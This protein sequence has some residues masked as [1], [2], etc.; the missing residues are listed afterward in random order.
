MQHIHSILAFSVSDLLVEHAGMVL[1]A[2]ILVLTLIFGLGDLLRFSGKRI[3][4][5]SSVCFAESIRRK[6]LWITPVAIIGVMVVAQLQRP[7]DEQDAIRQTTKFCLFATG[8]VV[9][10]VAILLAS[11]SLPKEI[12]NRVIFTIVT[13]PTTRLEIVLGK[14]LGFARVAAAILLIMGLFTAVYLQVRAWSLQ[15]DIALRL[16]T[17]AVD[18]L[19]RPALEHYRA[20]GLLN[21][22]TFATTE[23]L[24][25]YA[26]LPPVNETRR[27]QY[28]A[29]EG[30]IIVPFDLTN[31]MFIGANDPSANYSMR[32]ICAIGTKLAPGAKPPTTQPTTAEAPKGPITGPLPFVASTQPINNVPPDPGTFVAVSVL[33]TDE[34]VLVDSSA[35]GLS[36]LPLKR[37]GEQG[38]SAPLTPDAI[39]RMWIA[40]RSPDHNRVYICF[41]GSDPN[42]LY[43]ADPNS[44]YL[45]IRKTDAAGAI[46]TRT[47]MPPA[48]PNR[49]GQPMLPIY[50]GGYSRY[51]QPLRGS[52]EPGKVAV[53]HF[54]HAEPDENSDVVN[55]ELRLGIERS[56][57]DNADE[58]DTI[59]NVVAQIRNDKTGKVSDPITIQPETNRTQ[60]FTFPAADVLGGDYELTLRCTSPQHAVGI[61][62]VS[63]QVVMNS[64]HFYFNLFK[65]LTI[66]WL[67]AVLVV[68]VAIFCSTFVSW[69]IAVVLCVVIL[70]GRWGVE[71]LGD[72]TKPGIGPQV[73]MDFG[74]R[75]ANEVHVI[76]ESVETLTKLLNMLSHI[77]PDISQFPATED[78]ERGVSIPLSKLWESVTEATFYGAPL[79][80]MGYVIFKKKEVAP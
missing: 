78:I 65:S 72:A 46:T 51:G 9:V 14:T 53:Y 5:I 57:T 49:N 4:A 60:Y 64:G 35:S 17:G 69:P 34:A 25:F 58:A 61:Q 22:K 68:S 55:F 19:N 15:R 10:I 21:A 76:S 73:A 26:T 28:F 63:V 44:C 16:D 6:V 39:T 66:F 59:T 52:A 29:G 13:K 50:H 38:F 67:L 7:T 31:D 62:P 33:D 71:Q 3:W 47:V 18:P 11:T 54:R 56:G 32:V 12:E 75:N 77:L 27:Y 20:A 40:A 80:L 30:Q 48:D 23:D 42:Y 74:F 24:Q 45:E 41:A 36:R 70:L 2:I 37:D 79:L 1:A 43:F 8:M